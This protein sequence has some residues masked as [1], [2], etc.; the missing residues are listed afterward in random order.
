MTLSDFAV[1]RPV[2]AV[3]MNLI[4]IAFGVVAFDRLQVREYPNIDPPEV[5]IDTEYPG[6]AAQVIETRITEVIEDR[7]AGVEGIAFIESKSEDGRSRIN[8][9]FKTGR[10][11]DA[12]AND[13]RDRVSGVVDNLPD[14]AD[15][16][17]I[18]KVDS[19]DDV[20]MW[21]NLQSD[22]LTTEGLT[23]YAGSF[24]D[25][26]TGDTGWRCA[27]AD[28]RCPALRATDLAGSQRACRSWSG[29][30]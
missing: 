11:V 21:F 28:R 30:Q 8:I 6:T 17:D 20:I 14:E 7:I 27:G 23:D 5:S 13:I 29:G 15:P 1:T 12:A 18:Q 16:P 2:V 10:D 3:V 26:S 25:R 9:E 4:L 22:R 19:S 24:S